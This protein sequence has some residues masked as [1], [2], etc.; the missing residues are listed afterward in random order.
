MW[1]LVYFLTPFAN[2]VFRTWSCLTNQVNIFFI[3]WHITSSCN[4]TRELFSW[5]SGQSQFHVQVTSPGCLST[6]NL[7]EIKKYQLCSLRDATICC[8]W[9][10][11][12]EIRSIS[13]EVYLGVLALRNIFSNICYRFRKYSVV[14]LKSTERSV[15]LGDNIWCCDIVTSVCWQLAQHLQVLSGECWSQ[16]LPPLPAPDWLLYSDFL[17]SLWETSDLQAESSATN[18]KGNRIAASS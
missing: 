13:K 5:Y 4:V 14:T 2:N 10:W 16:R 11:M 15:N 7:Q 18:N 1:V 3:N 17:S 6:P 12:H 9:E 8:K